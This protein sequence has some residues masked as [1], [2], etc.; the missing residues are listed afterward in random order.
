MSFAKHA[1]KVVTRISNPLVKELTALR[2]DKSF[3]MRQ[4]QI[5][6]EGRLDATP[7]QHSMFS[8]QAIT[9]LWTHS[10]WAT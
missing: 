5:V 1:S 8:L 2:T 9:Q 7:T 4:K 3:R 10:H 6:I